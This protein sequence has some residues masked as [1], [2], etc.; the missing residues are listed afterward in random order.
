MESAKYYLDLFS[1]IGGFAL[2]A[3]WAGM[4]FDE[5][6]FSE[7]DN[8]AVQVYQKRFPEAKLLGDIRNVN[9]E[10]MP[11]GE[12]LVTGGF[13]CQPHSLAGKKKGAGD[14]RDLW[15]E[16][17]RML[18][19]L[20]PAIAL[21][22]N[23][24][25]LFVSNGGEFFNRVLS[26]ISESGY[27][28]EWQVISAQDAGA[29]HR[30]KRVWIVAYPRDRNADSFYEQTER[31][32]CGRETAQPSGIRPDVPY[33]ER[34]Q[35][36]HER[37]DS[38]R[39]R[40][41]VGRSGQAS[42]KENGE[43][44]TDR[45]C[46]L[47][48]N[49]AN[50]ESERCGTR[51]AEPERQPGELCPAGCCCSLADTESELW[52]GCG[53]TR[54][55]R[56]GLAD[57]GQILADTNNTVPARLRKYGGK[58]YAG[59]ETKRFD[60]R[61]CREWWAV[62]P[63]VGR[64]VNGLSCWLDE[65]GGLSNEAKTR[66]G[67]ILRD[68]RQSTIKKAYQWT[69]GR[70]DGVQETEV[71]LAFLCEYEERGIGSRIEMEGGA[72]EEEFVRSLW[73]VIESARSPYRRKYSKQYAGEYSDALRNLPRQTSSLFPQAWQDDCWEDGIARVASG[74]PSRVDRLRGIGNAIVP[75]CAEM[76]LSLP[77][78]DRWRVA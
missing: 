18:R 44:D 2:G 30:R 71:L 36:N 6:Y 7:I 55:G 53:N 75:Q 27:D 17:A 43:A 63:D 45:S 12:Y 73:H 22:E 32:I 64:I 40:H 65:F 62:E 66:A 28:A 35:D 5:H 15:P 21:F 77:A 3:Y 20:R 68:V 31:E 51:R 26:D 11:K 16:C 25:G 69:A 50:A 8:Y 49:V 24:P 72:D 48:A 54:S 19:E 76:I 1:G 10:K 58:I 67:K 70:F 29:P 59:S 57:G 47:C 13:P 60:E 37:R 23:V 4:R 56:N 34:Q 14:E 9:Y 52:E 38:K 61:S 33:A 46:G 78:F 41:A 39:G 42:F 74:I